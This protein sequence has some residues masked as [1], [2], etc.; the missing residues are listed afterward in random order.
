MREQMTDAAL[1]SLGSKTT[2]AGAT[3][4][5]LGWL[6]SNAVIGYAGLAIALVGLLVNTHYR[7][8]E[9]RRREREHVALMR[10]LERDYERAAG[11]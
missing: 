6:A 1:A 2:V 10:R 8:R 4:S 3:A 5:G 11:E 9:D 7:R